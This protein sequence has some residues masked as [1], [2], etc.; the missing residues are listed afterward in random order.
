MSNL[1]APH[2]SF[3]CSLPA[4]HQPPQHCAALFLYIPL[5]CSYHVLAYQSMASFLGFSHWLWLLEAGMKLQASPCLLTHRSCLMITTRTARIAVTKWCSHMTSHFIPHSL[6]TTIPVPTAVVTEGLKLSIYTKCLESSSQSHL[7][8][9]L[10]AS[11]FSLLPSCCILVLVA[12]DP[13]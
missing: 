9:F 7:N 2:T 12:I 6:V 4:L 3:P 5:P 1:E 11:L 13:Y 10:T 8:I